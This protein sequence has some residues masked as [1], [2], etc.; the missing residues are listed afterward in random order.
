[1]RLKVVVLAPRLFDQDPCHLEREEE[2]G[3]RREHVVA[4][5]P[6]L[7]EDRQELTSVL[8]DHPEHT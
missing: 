8:V 4:R 3:E 5:D 7:N 6:S 2:I 1:V